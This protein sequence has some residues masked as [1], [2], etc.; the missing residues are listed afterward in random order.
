MD[1][2][3]KLVPFFFLIASTSLS[4]EQ[5]K[6]EP[7][8]GVNIGTA[9][10]NFVS[11]PELV[12]F[13]QVQ[14]ISHVRLYDA[15]ADLLKALAK[16]KIKVI[17]S[18]PNNQLLAVG[19]SN[20]TAAAW[21]G[22]NV[23]AYFPDT[24]IT[25]VAVGDEVL[26]T[27]P[28]SAPLLMLAIESLYSALVAAN[29]HTQIKI[30]TPNSAS[31]ILDPFPPSQAFFNQSL[32]PVLTNLLQFLSR[33]KSPLMM[34]LYPYYV[35]MQNKG[36]VP[37]DNSLFKPLTPSKEMVDPNT[38]LH[39]TNVLDAMI[40]S[41]YFSMKNLNFTDVAVVVSETGWPSAGD[42]KEPYATID[43]ADTYNSNLIKHISD[44]PGTPLHPE[45]TPSV[46]IYELFNEDLRSLPLSE[47]NWGL[48]YANSTPVYLLHVS[49]SGAF[50]ANDTTN[51]TYC[52]ASDGIDTKTLQSALDWAC[53]PGRANCS[54][55]Q[56]GETCYQPNNVKNHASYAFD[57]YYQK[58]SRISGSCDFKGAALI[59]TSDPSHGNCIFPGSKL[60]SNNKTRQV[61]NS[62]RASSDD[63][64]TSSDVKGSLFCLAFAVAALLFLT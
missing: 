63:R 49:G 9:V 41:V 17:V 40:D 19:S 14:K 3:I 64:V 22:R 27:T 33:T 36:V 4:A 61:V 54:Q 53:G 26:T 12:A 28:S 18:V 29:L 35:F 7:F 62:T 8:V 34:N 56:P 10:S 45:T 31:I 23:A 43:N 52:V 57:S 58:E 60:V 21:I 42:S 51:Q 20:A 37:L 13:L 15:D 11:P 32:A 5:D 47:A 6:D 48:F 2:L 1:V 59:T 50:L 46:Y 55:I 25:A 30:S 24:L 44:R 38:L 39:Y 16:T